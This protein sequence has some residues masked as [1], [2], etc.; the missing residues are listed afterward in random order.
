MMLPDSVQGSELTALVVALSSLLLWI[1]ERFEITKDLR[2]SRKMLRANSMGRA[3][4]EVVRQISFKR[5]SIDL[6]IGIQSGIIFVVCLL[7][8]FAPNPA[9]TLLSRWTIAGVMILISLAV[10]R[11]AW[12]WKRNNERMLSYARTK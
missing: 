3:E 1:R 8:T 5:R 10:A 2:L 7:L 11:Y 4:I 9:S 6:L 12:D